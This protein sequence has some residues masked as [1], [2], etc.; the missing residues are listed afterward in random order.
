MSVR[1]IWAIVSTMLEEAALVAVVLWGLPQ[2]GIHIPLPALIALMVAWAAFAVITYRL[3]SRALRRK[4]VI[5][6]LP[7]VGNKGKVVSRLDPEGLVRIKGE[8]WKAK[9]AGGRMDTGEEV[10][11]VGQEGLKLI[12]RKGD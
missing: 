9:S 7:M 6:L 11:V 2:L 4:P 5:D 8:L 1:L 10:T 3:G 12:V